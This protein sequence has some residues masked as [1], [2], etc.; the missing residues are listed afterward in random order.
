[1]IIFTIGDIFGIILL[2]AVVVYIIYLALWDKVDSYKKQKPYH[3]KASKT[4]PKEAPVKN[5]PKSLAGVIIVLAF[6]AV[7][8]A[9]SIIVAIK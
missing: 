9:I 2:I 8:L 1:M 7:A 3:E 5:E 4:I 6:F